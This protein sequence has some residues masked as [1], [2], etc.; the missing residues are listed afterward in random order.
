M[1]NLIIIGAGDFA[2]EVYWHAQDCIG[3]GSDWTV[4]GFIDGD[5]KLSAEEY[6]RLPSDVPLL[7]DIDSYEIEP[8]D[9][10][11]CAIGT[12]A[13]RKKLVEKILPRGAKFINVIH[14][15][16]TVM[17]RAKLGRGVVICLANGIGDLV[18]LGDFVVINNVTYLG[19]D[20]KVGDYT[21]IMSHVEI[22]GGAV[23]GNEVF[24]GSQVAIAPKSK[25]GDGAFVG[26][27]SVVI[28]D[29]PADAKFLGNPARNF[30]F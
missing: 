22:G 26:I 16:S 12:P 11:A 17:P 10:F 23:I 30:N 27:G 5:V 13:V 25:I 7:G 8:D 9:V 15:R 29:V 19:H 1:K 14:R 6:Q 4:K 2:R 24:I 28:G 18:E 21:C 20:V 3:F